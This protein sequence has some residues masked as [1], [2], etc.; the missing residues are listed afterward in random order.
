MKVIFS[1]YYGVRNSGDDAFIEVAA[2]G[3]N[4]FWKADEQIFIAKEL[5]KIISPAKHIY[6]HRDY[7]NFA[8]TIREIFSSDAFV[9]AGGSTFQSS[10]TLKDL[11]TY[12]K[13]KK[14]LRI[15]GKSGAIGISL[16]PFRNVAA[17]K[18]TRE[19][20]KTLNFLA[21]RDNTSYEMACSYDLPYKPVNAFDLAALLPTIYGLEQKQKNKKSV[22][23]ISVCNYESYF[24]GDVKKEKKRNEFICALINSLKK[25]PTIRFRFF[26]FNG[27]SKVGDEA[28]TQQI[29]REV[30][31]S[32]EI[33]FEIIPYH[34]E[35][36][37]MFR[38]ISE[39][40]ILV[41][42]RLHAAIFACY[43]H[44]PFFLLEYHRKCTDFLDDIGQSDL[45]RLNDADVEVKSIV[46]EIENI[47][48]NKLSIAP[49]NLE[50]TIGK[51]FLNFTD[52]YLLS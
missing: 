40:D 5:P 19:Y 12:S 33:D 16:G 6:A 34:S 37:E 31:T 13:L 51:A 9:S 50:I 35:V 39:C 2:W 48:F 30:N 7:W 15:K 17:E 4:K 43:S 3:C 14:K 38:K 23:G 45:Y 27:S 21:L 25:N 20:L 47:L 28:L 26:I 11:R 36:K 49:K 24:N 41:S 32:R 1:G 46:Q 22:I 8:R 18:S 42:T 52:T 10:L 44:I 29:I